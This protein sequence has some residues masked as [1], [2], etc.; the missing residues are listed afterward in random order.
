MK[1]N[2]DP[3]KREQ[4]A[5]GSIVKMFPRMNYYKKAYRIP[6]NLYFLSKRKIGGLNWLT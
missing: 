2:S 3:R 4:R 1:N 6:G 5:E